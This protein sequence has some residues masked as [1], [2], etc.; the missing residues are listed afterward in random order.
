MLSCVSEFD[1]FHSCAG[2]EVAEDVPLLVAIDLDTAEHGPKQVGMRGGDAHIGRGV[3]CA[4]PDSPGGG[5]H[6]APGNRAAHMVFDE[7]AAQDAGD[8]AGTAGGGLHGIVSAIRERFGLSQAHARL[9][10]TAA[11]GCPDDEA[12]GSPDRVRGVFPLPYL[13][14]ERTAAGAPLRAGARRRQVGRI[15]PCPRRT[16]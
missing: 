6:D 10:T 13:A 9:L 3:P 2:D 5:A 7:A 8:V 11:A 14:S 4:T 1:D 16:S 12:G 15:E